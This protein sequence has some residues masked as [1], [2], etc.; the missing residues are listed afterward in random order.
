MDTPKQD[1]RLEEQL[2]LLRSAVAHGRDPILI[3]EAPTADAG[4][5]IVFANPAFLRMTGYQEDEIVGNTTALLNGPKTDPAALDD[6]RR[7]A[8]A[9]QPYFGQNTHYRKD[10]S[11]FSLEWQVSPLCDPCGT[12]T[13]YVAVL[14]D[15]TVHRKKEEEQLRSELWFRQVWVKSHDGMRLTDEH[16][17]ILMVNEA[18]CRIVGRTREALEG[19][20]FTTI[21]SE[22]HRDKLLAKYRGRFATRTVEP[23]FVKEQVLW[24][25]RKIFMEASNSFLEV[26]GQPPLLLGIM[27]DVTEQKRLEEQFRQSQKMEEIGKLAGGVAHDFNNIL[28]VITG[29]TDILIRDVAPSNPSFEMLREIRRSG[30]RAALLTRQL[31]A[32]SRKQILQPQILNLNSLVLDMENLLRRII[33]EDVALVTV[34]DPA[35]QRVRA[36]PGQL[37][38]VIMNLAVNARDAMARGGKLTIET[39]N[40]D[41]DEA[42]LHAHAEVKAGSYVML[43]VSDTGCGMT[44][45]VKQHVFEP[46]FTTKAVG[47]GT[48]LGLATVYGIVKQSGGHIWL[49]SE[50]GQGTAFKIYFPAVSAAAAEDRARAPGAIPAGT[51]TILLVEDDNAVRA[52]V[53][54]AL[55][56]FGY[57]VLEAANGEQAVRLCAETPETIDLLIT[58]VVMPE[59]SGREVAEAITKLKPAVKV[60]YISG[61]TDDAVVRHGVLQAEA[62]FLQKPFTTPALAHKVRSL[63]GERRT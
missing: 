1:P 19:Q 24:D 29:Y 49:Y 58:D 8:A 36:D 13:Y 52:M 18:Y 38:Q 28:T 56:T 61:Y 9:G 53:R 47:K 15:V 39:A 51:E 45:E 63:L 4:A 48:G 32:F 2:L 7:Q 20:L 10:G 25:G 54:F 22:R 43:A 62:A 33:G 12:I 26:P 60:L 42:Y 11:E 46:F 14:H 59:M 44:N 16:G 34:L 40:I 50:A 6:M 21:Y 31:L 30:E 23:H 3:T 37:Q 5:R 17:V 27:R 57:K 35:L 41:F 55:T